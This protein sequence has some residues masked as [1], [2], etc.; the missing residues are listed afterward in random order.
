MAALVVEGVGGTFGEQWSCRG[1]AS[2]TVWSVGSVGPERVGCG[3]GCGS[4]TGVD[5]GGEKEGMSRTL[6]S[7]STGGREG[8]PADVGT[9]RS[10][11][12]GTRVPHF[13][14]EKSLLVP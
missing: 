13:Y 8:G 5:G 3:E 2:V 9:V 6:V 11:R 14:P 1:G 7:R 4:R 10:R 12:F